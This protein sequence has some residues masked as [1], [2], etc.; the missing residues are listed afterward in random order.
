VV[1][2]QA[3]VGGSGG[4]EGAVDV[5]GGYVAAG[6]EEGEHGGEA[7]VAGC[8]GDEDVGVL[9]VE[10]EVGEVHCWVWVAGRTCLWV[11]L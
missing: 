6:G 4:D 2:G 3:R 11:V 8:A 7:Q 9:E 1:P 5:E 10:G